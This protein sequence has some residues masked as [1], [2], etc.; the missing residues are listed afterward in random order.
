MKTLQICKWT[1]KMVVLGIALAA[2]QATKTNAELIY[3][4]SDQLGDLV[5]FD[6]ASPQTIITATSISGTATGEQIR[7]LDFINGILYALGDQSHLYTI[8]PT[9]GV[10]TQVGSGQFSPA[11]NGFD[12]GFNAGPTQLYVTS[13]L[14]QNL[15]LNPLTGAATAGPNYSGATSA[16]DST[17]Y[18]FA[19]GN[20]YAISASTHDLYQI[21]PV[22]G[23][24][25]LIGATGV[26]FVDRVSFD[27]SPN[28]G[29][30]YF[31]GTVGSPGQTELFTVDL[32]TGAMT[33]V[34]T[35]ANPGELSEG[36]DAI[37]VVPIPE[38]G[39]A[40]LFVVGGSCFLFRLIRRRG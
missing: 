22:T 17:A 34:N 11:L 39:T 20:F 18:D 13:D 27:I 9:T 38:P 21:N 7:G 40:A 16:L 25:T 4:V 29:T 2:V 31:S 23:S 8:D 30:A 1:G 35:I 36:L 10:A 28:S 6:S 37:A 32:N 3:G 15:T 12:F 33:L 19:T 5:S 26:S 24:V 14:G